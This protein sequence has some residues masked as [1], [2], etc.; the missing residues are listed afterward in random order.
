M[1]MFPLLEEKQ[2]ERILKRFKI[3]RY[4]NERIKEVLPFI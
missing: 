3:Y 2:P 4:F 1:A